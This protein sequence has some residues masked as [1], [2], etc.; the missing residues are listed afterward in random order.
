MKKSTKWIIAIAS[1]LAVIA[2]VG[3]VCFIASKGGDGRVTKQIALAERYFDELDYEQAIAA[4]K[5][6]L[7]LDPNNVEAYHG[8]AKA[9]IAL[10]DYEAAAAIL[11]EGIDITSSEELRTLLDEVNAK[12]KETEEAKKAE[13]QPEKEEEKESEEPKQD[14]SA[15]VRTEKIVYDDGSFREFS[16][17]FR[18]DVLHEVHY[19]AAGTWCDETVCEYTLDGNVTEETK[20]YDEEGG[21]FHYIRKRDDQGRQTYFA[22]Y[23]EDGSAAWEDW[24]TYYEDG[25]WHEYHILTEADGSSQAYEYQRDAAGKELSYTAYYPN[26][27]VISNECQYIY[28]ADGSWTEHNTVYYEDGRVNWTYDIEY[29]ADGTIR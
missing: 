18:E 14:L 28:H 20:G 8:M 21:Y 22:T 25:S 10:G 11:A 3:T 1:A 19:N 9:Y 29:N 4:Y 12:I 17:N 2:V 26:S 16:Y 5:V 24:Y 15:I 7:E 13:A 6:V 27:T 23:R